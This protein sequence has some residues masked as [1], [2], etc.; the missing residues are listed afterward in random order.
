MH[1]KYGDPYVGVRCFY[2]NFPL[3]QNNIFFW[4]RLESFL[5]I[6]I[7]IFLIAIREIIELAL[8]E[9]EVFFI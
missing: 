2:M 6:S 5:A 8:T 9:I 7:N 3:N 4:I 1:G